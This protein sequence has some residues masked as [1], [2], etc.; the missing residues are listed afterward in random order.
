MKYRPEI[1]GLRAI[2]VLSVVLFHLGDK[3][4]SGGY[5][6]VDVFFVISGYLITSLIRSE[7]QRGE[8]SL[9]SFYV[10]RIKRI[11]P[12]L[13]AVVLATIALGYLVLPP[14]DY[15]LLAQS[16]RFALAGASNFFFREHT[17]Y[18]DPLA[19][20]MPLLHTWSLGVEEQFYVVWPSLLIVLGSVSR[21]TTIPI[22]FFLS[23]IVVAS[24]AS[25]FLVGEK[26]AFYMPY[27]RAW[28]LG[29]GAIIALLPE[30]PSRRFVRF[31]KVLFWL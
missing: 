20:T 9:V 11:A 4:V 19:D 29:L 16:G 26:E 8:F 10:R 23:A 25:F 15:E 12:A 13:L 6:G 30:L 27:A 1:D 5:V 21:K 18:F 14:G 2:A 28:E 22:L 17:G 24:L 31:N 7:R 3:V